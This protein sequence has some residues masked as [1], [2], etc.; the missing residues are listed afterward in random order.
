VIDPAHGRE[1]IDLARRRGVELLVG[2]PLHWNPQALALRDAIARGR[3]GRLEH[4]SVLYAST[5]RELYGGAP[6][7]YR[8]DVFAYPVSAPAAATYRNP[9]LA[10]G[11]QGQ[12]QV[13]HAAALLLWLT[14]L[15]PRSVMAFTSRFELPVDLADALAIS[16]DGGAVGT[17]GS[18]GGVIPGHEE[19]VRCELFGH[20]GHVVF[21]VNAGLA[22]I[23]DAD[24]VELLPQPTPAECYP[25]RAPARSLVEAA[26]GRGGNRSP[27]EV[28]LNTA[29]LIAAMYR[30][31]AEARMVAIEEA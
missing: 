7:R 29:E 23:H 22:T 19:I 11:G 3:I 14:G 28:G 25:E 12:S 17:L 15:R 24:G 18:T 31:A 13:S 8:D 1:L 30:S 26:L 2:F 21:D 20:D 4:V 9:E 10:G 16:F 6:E 5:V 27:G